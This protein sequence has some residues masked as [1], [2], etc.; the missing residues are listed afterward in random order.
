VAVGS[1]IGVADIE[2][3]HTPQGS[4]LPGAPNHPSK[5]AVAGDGPWQTDGNDRCVA[6]SGSSVAAS[7]RKR[8]IRTRAASSGTSVCKWRCNHPLV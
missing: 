6:T 8:R 4:Q 3:A 7:S 5:Q 2:P 1:G